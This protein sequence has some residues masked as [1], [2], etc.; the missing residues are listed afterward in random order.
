MAAALQ[1]GRDLIVAETHLNRNAP[2]VVCI[3]SMGPR[4]NSRGDHASPC[5]RNTISGL[6]WGRDLIVA[7]TPVQ[8]VWQQ[9]TYVLLQWGRDLIVAETRGF[10]GGGTTS[11]RASMGPRLN[12]RG[13]VRPAVRSTVPLTLQWG[14]DLIVAETRI[15]SSRISSCP[16]SASMGPRL[17][18]RG[19]HQ[20]EALRDRRRLSFNGAAT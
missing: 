2:Q 3:A 12:S 9:G 7:E 6:Q 5:R 10:S 17:N 16:G 1:W 19:D 11:G 4:L 15:Y 8:P 20:L 14:R 13:D 18:S